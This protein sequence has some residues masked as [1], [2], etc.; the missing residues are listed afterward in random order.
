MSTL[1]I[2]LIVAGLLV[3][4]LLVG[5]LVAMRRYTEAHEDEYRQHLAAADQALEAARAA[6]RGWDRQ[7]MEDVARTALDKTHPGWDS[8]SLDLVLVDDQP[9]IERDRA[10]FEASDGD[11]QLR[12]V[13]TRGESGWTADEVG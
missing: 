12:V 5:G 10:Q 4:A 6:D 7:V 1:A 3:L 11:K 9:G 8:R 2:I 13:L